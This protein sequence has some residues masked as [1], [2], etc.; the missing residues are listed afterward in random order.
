MPT[1]GMKIISASNPNPIPDLNAPAVTTVKVGDP[2]L[3][4]W[5]LPSVSS[6]NVLDCRPRSL[7][8]CVLGMFGLRVRDCTAENKRGARVQILKDG[9]A[10]LILLVSPS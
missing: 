10:S 2:V 1:V 4:V 8:G 9:Y 7:S 6:K 3:F 5:H